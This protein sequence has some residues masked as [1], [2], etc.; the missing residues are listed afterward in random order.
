MDPA[1]NQELIVPISPYPD[2]SPVWEDTVTDTLRVIADL[3]DPADTAATGRFKHAN[4]DTLD[5]MGRPRRLEHGR[6][7]AG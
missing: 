2:G 5:E 6:A 7:A 3:G 4:R 1:G